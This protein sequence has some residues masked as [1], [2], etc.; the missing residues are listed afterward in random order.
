[1]QSRQ[2][3]LDYAVVSAAW[4]LSAFGVPNAVKRL[5]NIWL[6]RGPDEKGIAFIHH[7]FRKPPIDGHSVEWL[8][9]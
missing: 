1:M 3:R 8:M 6:E 4:H 2:D 9:G 7:Y 5:L